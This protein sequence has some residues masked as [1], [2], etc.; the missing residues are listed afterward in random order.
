MQYL[1]T[2]TYEKIEDLLYYVITTLNE[3][4]KPI[5]VKVRSNKR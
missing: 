2:I 1:I 3:E 4:V 5:Y